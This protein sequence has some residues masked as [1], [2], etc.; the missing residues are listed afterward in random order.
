MCNIFV[1]EEFYFKMFK[2]EGRSGAQSLSL[3]NCFSK[4][5]YIF[6]M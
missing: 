2:E 4:W 1:S 6:K 3:H 5:Q